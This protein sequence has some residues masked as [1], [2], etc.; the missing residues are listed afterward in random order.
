MDKLFLKKDL[1]TGCK[2]TQDGVLAYIAL[3][4]IIDESIPLYNKTSS[5]DCVSL[6]RMAYALVGSQ[7]KY[8]KVFLD[9]LQRGIYELKFENV[10]D[11]LQDFS[12]KTSY[13]YLLNMA[14]MRLDTEKD[15][16]MFVYPK[17][18]YRILTCD[19]L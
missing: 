18:V 7:K 9:S 11:I 2:L 13:E 6:N 5:V 4:T 19:E 8:E 10:L 3:R 12:T 16:F 17:E 15:N 1:V 14:N